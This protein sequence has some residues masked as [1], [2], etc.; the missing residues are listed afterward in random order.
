MVQGQEGEPTPEA[1]VTELAKYPSVPLR[2]TVRWALHSDA[3]VATEIKTSQNYVFIYFYLSY[4][5]YIFWVTWLN[6]ILMTN[7]VH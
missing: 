5:I 4:P 6:E 7:T 3:P 1:A 2:T